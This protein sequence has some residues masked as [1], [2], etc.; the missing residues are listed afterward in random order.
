MHAARQLHPRWQCHCFSFDQLRAR[1]IDVIVREVGPHICIKRDLPGR[2]LG[3][4]NRGAMMPPAA[5]DK[6]VLRLNM[7]LPPGLICHRF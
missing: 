2:L 3:G 4:A 6:K 7:T 1:D 5:S